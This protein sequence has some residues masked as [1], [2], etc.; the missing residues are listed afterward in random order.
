MNNHETLIISCNNDKDVNITYESNKLLDST[1]NTTD[2]V[3]L[4]P[5]PLSIDS[6]NSGSRNFFR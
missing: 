2:S 1:E 4:T 6:A 3:E 5:T